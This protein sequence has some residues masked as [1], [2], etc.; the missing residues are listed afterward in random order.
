MNRFML[1][2]TGTFLAMALTSGMAI[3]QQHR[4]SSGGSRPSSAPTQRP[5]YRPSQPTTQRTAS[6]HVATGT[7]RSG[8]VYKF[9]GGYYYK[10]GWHNHWNYRYHAANYGCTLY[11][12][13]GCQCYY[14]W[15]PPDDCYY[16]VSYCPYGQYSWDDQ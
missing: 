13:D 4:G 12:D 3:G 11:Y 8:G 15:C 6:H 14:Y 9:K 1:S 2:V 16:P 5:A 10:G 7:Q